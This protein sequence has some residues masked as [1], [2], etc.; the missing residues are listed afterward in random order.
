MKKRKQLIL[1]VM[2]FICAA[3]GKA[4]A[5]REPQSVDQYLEEGKTIVIAKC[6]RAGPVKANLEGDAK[7]QILRVLKGT[8]KEREILI[9]SRFGLEPGLIYLLRTEREAL[10]V[11]NYFYVTSRASAVPLRPYEDL[12]LLK[13]LPLRTQV[14]RIFNERQEELESE[15]RSLSFERDALEQVL[16]KQ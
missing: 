11:D 9:T 1:A 10:P 5:Q 4:Q 15:I 2:L 6:L 14:I 8:E 13:T 16:K 3:G 7:I 12:E